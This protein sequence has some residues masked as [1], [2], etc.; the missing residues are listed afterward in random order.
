MDTHTINSYK[1]LRY[2]HHIPKGNLVSPPFL[3]TY[4]YEPS[5]QVLALLDGLD[6]IRVNQ[7][8][9]S[10][11]GLMGP[12]TKLTWSILYKNN[13]ISIQCNG[14]TE[15]YAFLVVIFRELLRLVTVRDT[16]LKFRF[17]VELKSLYKMPRRQVNSSTSNIEIS[18]RV[19]K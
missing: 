12:R 8:E 2:P 11:R 18:T 5:T 14:V 1:T 13:K 10:L 9:G 3:R 15:H 4:K 19:N 6:D 17:Q 7:A 16:T